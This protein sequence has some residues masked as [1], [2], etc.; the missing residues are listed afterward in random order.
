MAS[1]AFPVLNV[2][3]ASGSNCIS[4]EAI[5]RQFVSEAV[6]AAGTFRSEIDRASSRD[7]AAAPLLQENA[8][9]RFAIMVPDIPS[10]RVSGKSRTT[11][12]MTTIIMRPRPDS[13]TSRLRRCVGEVRF[14]SGNTAQGDGS[15]KRFQFQLGKFQCRTLSVR[16]GSP[17]IHVLERLA[18]GGRS[19]VA[20]RLTRGWTNT[21]A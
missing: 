12:R 11:S 18:G 4:R 5:N 17:S 14:M 7:D 20:C 10:D 8:E 13:A 19:S 6:I 2:H 15:W 9:F 3:A 21:A 16:H 1:S